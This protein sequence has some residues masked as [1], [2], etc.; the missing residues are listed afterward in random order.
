[1]ESDSDLVQRTL[2]GETESFRALVER[3]QDAVYGVA[4]SKTGSF[5]DAEDLAQEIF[6]AAYE[7]LQRLKTPA[8]FGSWLYGIALN[9]TKMHLR[10]QTLSRKSAV[11]AAPNPLPADELATRNETRAAIIAALKS[12]SDT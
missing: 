5:A 9:K 4:L 10:S 7:S 12:L 11:Q 6:L 8:K 3:Y 2:A 1:M